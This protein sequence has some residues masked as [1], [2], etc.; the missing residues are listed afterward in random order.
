LHQV[1]YRGG[2]NWKVW[3]QPLHGQDW[4]KERYATSLRAFWGAEAARRQGEEAFQRFHRALLRRVHKDTLALA[5][6]QTLLVAA[7]D[8]GLDLT[9]FQVA[10]GDPSCLERLAKD[11][12][13]AVGRGVFGTPTFVFPRAEPAY[14]KL[15][16]LLTPEESLDFWQAFRGTVIDRPY[17]LEIKR[18]H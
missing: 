5:D 18:P 8:A 1:N 4:E 2:D 12:T 7:R 15:T 10:L 6:S 3:E 14:L 11:H 17:V 16:R 9:R 13:T